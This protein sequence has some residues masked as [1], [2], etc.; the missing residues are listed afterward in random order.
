[1][2]DLNGALDDIQV[3]YSCHLRGDATYRHERGI[4]A[5]TV[6]LDLQNHGLAITF[7]RDSPGYS[8]PVGLAPLSILLVARYVK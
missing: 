8:K 2:K 6:H 1:M 5:D 7:A 3:V 4:V